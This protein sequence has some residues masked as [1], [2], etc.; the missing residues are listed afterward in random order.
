MSYLLSTA[1]LNDLV[2]QKLSMVGF[3]SAVNY[4]SIHVSVI[5]AGILYAE[6]SALPPSASSKHNL[7]INLDV[8]MK[9]VESSNGVRDISLDI[10]NSWVQ[11]DGLQLMNSM[12][13]PLGM[14][15]TLV[16]ATALVSQLTLVT[17]VEPWL[18]TLKARGLHV[19]TY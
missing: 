18:P 14:E 6:I 11:L 10:I 9:K 2:S 17:P 1:A 7:K 15:S 8:I 3:A 12:G 13:Q 4:N 16:F 19:H 5:S